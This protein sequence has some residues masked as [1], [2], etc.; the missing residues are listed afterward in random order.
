[1]NSPGVGSTEWLWKR[2]AD[3]LPLLW[4]DEAPVPAEVLPAD[5]GRV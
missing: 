2:G 5:T 1:M 4:A 3:L